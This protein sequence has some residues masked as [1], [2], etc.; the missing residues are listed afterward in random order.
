VGSTPRALLKRL[1]ELKREAVAAISTIWRSSQCFRSSAKTASGTAAGDFVRA[2]AKPT[3]ARSAGVNS[4]GRRSRR[5]STW[6]SLTP[7]R[8]ASPVWEPSQ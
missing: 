6:A 8:R 7:N 1:K 2:S 3:A 5:Q 4:A